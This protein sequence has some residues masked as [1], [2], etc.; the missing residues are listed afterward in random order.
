MN[1]NA[2]A[3]YSAGETTLKAGEDGVAGA[4]DGANEQWLE[5]EYQLE[6]PRRI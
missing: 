5:S 1:Q 3:M 4:A 2:E 6:L